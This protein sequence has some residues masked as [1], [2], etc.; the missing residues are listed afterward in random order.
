MHRD[1]GGYKVKREIISG[2]D[3]GPKTS[4]NMTRNLGQD[5]GFIVLIDILEAIEKNNINLSYSRWQWF[6][7]YYWE[8]Q[9]WKDC[10]AKVITDLKNKGFNLNKCSYF[11]DFIFEK[12]VNE[13][14][15]STKGTHP[16]YKQAL[17]ELVAR[18]RPEKR[19]EREYED[20]WLTPK[21]LAEKYNKK[22][23]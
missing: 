20:L 16:I 7:G 4:I 5:I 19:K 15:K 11:L 23:R 3:S 10:L 12:T 18:K 13:M 22:E 14:V 1:R 6:I 21:E 8:D 2:N 17:M 9:I